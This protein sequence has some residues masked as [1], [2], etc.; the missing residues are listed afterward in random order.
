V[1]ERFDEMPRLVVAVALS[2]TSK[3]IEGPIDV[4]AANGVHWGARLALTT[5][6]LHIP[7]LEL[8]LV[9]LGSGYNANLIKD[10]VEVLW[11]QTRRLLMVLLTVP[12]NSLSASL[13]F[14]L[15]YFVLSLLAVGLKLM[16]DV[17]NPEMI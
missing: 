12:R 8:K 5:V 15:F 9:L 2:L 3:G 14:F 16:S 6:L 13:S 10:E 17:Y 7:K 11:I 1:L 4:A